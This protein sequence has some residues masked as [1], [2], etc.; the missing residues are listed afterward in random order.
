M[1]SK[2]L[3][4]KNAKNTVLFL[5]KNKTVFFYYFF[6]NLLLPY[7][8]CVKKIINISLVKKLCFFTGRSRGFLRKFNMSRLYFR[9]SSQKGYLNG[10]KKANW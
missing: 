9:K 7:L 5:Y 4:T 3:I 2:A 10:V 8:L 6:I 1:S